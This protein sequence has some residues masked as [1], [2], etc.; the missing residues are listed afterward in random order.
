MPSTI[1]ATWRVDWAVRSAS[2]RTSSARRFNSGVQRQH[3]G[4]IRD[5]FDQ[6]D[7]TPDLTAALMQ[8]TDC[9][10]GLIEVIGDGLN[11]STGLCND[12]LTATGFAQ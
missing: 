10:D 8:G 4:L 2:R 11:L 1:L 6:T 7:Q 12:L 3:L 9:L 5:V